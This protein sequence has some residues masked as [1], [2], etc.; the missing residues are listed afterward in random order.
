MMEYLEKANHSMYVKSEPTKALGSYSVLIL[1]SHKSNGKGLELGPGVV[2]PNWGHNHT[3]E[4]IV[5]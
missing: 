1:N 5:F 4:I 2:F 3:G